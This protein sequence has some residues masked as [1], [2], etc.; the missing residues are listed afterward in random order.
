MFVFEKIWRALFSLNTRFEIRPFASL[1]TNYI[2]SILL[3][4]AMMRLNMDQI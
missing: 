3:K 1:L 4:Y 2:D